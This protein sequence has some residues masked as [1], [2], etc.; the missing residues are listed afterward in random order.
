MYTLAAYPLLLWG[1]RLIMQMGMNRLQ[2]L[3][4]SATGFVVMLDLIHLLR[5]RS[6][7][8][9]VPPEYLLLLYCAAM[10]LLAVRDYISPVIGESDTPLTLIYYGMLPIFMVVMVSR[11]RQILVLAGLP[12]FVYALA[13][14][15]A[16][17]YAASFTQRFGSL[18]EE[19]YGFAIQA[20]GR[21]GTFTRVQL[22]GFPGIV[23]GGVFAGLCA[24]CALH[25]FF[26]G[27][28]R[29]W[30]QYG[31]LFGAAGGAIIG[32]EVRSTIWVM[33]VVC[34]VLGCLVIIPSYYQR[35]G[36]VVVSFLLLLPFVYPVLAPAFEKSAA[37]NVGDRYGRVG[38]EDIFALGG[39]REI[40]DYVISA[41]KS[42]G[43]TLMGNG[44]GTET[45]L[46]LGEF[47][48][49]KGIINPRVVLSMHAHNAVLNLLLCGG[50]ISTILFCLT[51]LVFIGFLDA[52][53]TRNQ[54]LGRVLTIGII[55]YAVFESLVSPSYYYFHGILVIALV[56][57]LTPLEEIDLRDLWRR[58]GNQ[59][60]T[61]EGR[62][63]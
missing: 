38:S 50:L 59:W 42:D 63:A 29:H 55:A 57:A 58:R 6:R 1:D 27:P 20:S 44:L 4:L 28:K 60:V 33:A 32:T 36:L 53:Q 11:Q 47:A 25:Q 40:W 41:I 35:V 8:R 10:L 31:L 3:W 62:L 2:L 30:M 12:V 21:F 9:L 56:C 24:V 15:C 26:T 52:Q 45:T 7:G 61:P 5:I 48:V 13:L 51:P 54:T 17:A 14:V 18:A 43:L 19:K 39:R 23:S 34:L 46:G 16:L 37:S 22:P 49:Q